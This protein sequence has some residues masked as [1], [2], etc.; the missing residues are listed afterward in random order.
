[1]RCEGEQKT[2]GSSDLI[3]QIKTR[4]R[5]DGIDKSDITKVV[6]PKP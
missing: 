1:M 3:L 5:S 2:D 6:I 4:I